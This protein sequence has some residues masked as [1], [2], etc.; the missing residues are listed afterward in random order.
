MQRIFVKVYGFSDAERHALDTVFRLSEARET[1]VYSAWTP[2]APEAPSVVLIDGDN[3]EAVLALANPSHDALKLIWVGEGAPGLAWRAFPAP[4]QWSAVVEAMDKEFAPLTSLALSINLDLLD[5]VDLEAYF[6][7][8]G[9]DDTAPL[10][11]ES[12]AA[13]AAVRRV[14]VVDA[15]REER[16][17]LR[18]KLAVAGLFEVDEAASGAEALALLR[19]QAYRLVTVDLGVTDMD[20]WQLIRAVDRTRPAIAH[21]FVTGPALA[22]HQSWRLRL[23]GAQAYLKK[24][25]HPE[26]L[27][28][29]LQKI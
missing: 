29:L 7:D 3:G 24:P 27:Q 25:F 16:L 8:E 14:L 20:G 26:R 13:P 11:L 17:Y 5:E 23:C 4:V 18:A 10:P 21:L 19:T 2:Q 22:W 1:V 15:A 28:K 9:G 6:F 12:G